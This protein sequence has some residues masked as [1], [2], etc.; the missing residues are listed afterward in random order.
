MSLSLNYF[1]RSLPVRSTSSIALCVL[2][3]TLLPGA[4]LLPGI[5]SAGTSRAA[6]FAAASYKISASQSSF[7]VHAGVHGLLSSFGH[8]HNIAVKDFSG[9]ARF[10]PDNP[11]AS[12]LDLRVRAASLTV[13]DK[14]KEGDKQSIEKT[15]REQVLEVS[16]YPEIAFKST[17]VS[18]AKTGEGQ[19]RADMWG[20][21]SLHGVTKRGFIRAAVSIQGNTLRAKGEF[22]VIQTDYKIEPVSVVGGTIKVKNELKL[23]FDLVANKE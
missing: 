3:L 16:K 19:Y 2:G 14:I 6:A 1:A 9:T 4:S 11:S 22:P 20:D 8:N 13:I 15:M 17:S 7:M 12:G 5:A 18:I 10:D 21:L 23:D